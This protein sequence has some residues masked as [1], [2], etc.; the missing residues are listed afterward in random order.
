MSWEHHQRSRELSSFLGISFVVFEFK[1]P[2]FLRHPAA[3]LKTIAYLLKQRPKTLIIQCPSII[4]G[5]IAAVLKPLI[6]YTYIVDAHNA[7]IVKESWFSQKFYFLYKFVHRSA[8][9]TIVSNEDL[10]EIVENNKGTAFILPDKLF[11]PP[12]DKTLSL[13]GEKNAVL[14]CSFTID[15]PYEEVIEAFVERGDSTL[16]ITGNP[17]EGLKEKYEAHSHLVFTGFTPLE[18]YF[19]LLAS[20]DCIIALTTRESCLLCSA[21]EAVSFA[22]PFIT[23]NTRALK[24]YFSKGTIYTENNTEAIKQSYQTLLDNYAS[25]SQDMLEL[26]PALEQSWLKQGASFKALVCG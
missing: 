21:Y 13:Q 1:L 20:V 4:L 17:P 3:A 24:N 22:K 5:V 16:Y 7:A 15:E 2:R 25:L 19:A 9:V 8:D 18:D 12:L 26:K 23:S 14:V 6:N 10:V 11:D